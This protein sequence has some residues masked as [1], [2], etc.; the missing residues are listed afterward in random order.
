MA[1]EFLSLQVITKSKSLDTN[2]LGYYAASL[3][4]RSRRF[5]KF[6][7]FIFKDTEVREF[8]GRAERRNISA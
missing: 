2:A 8:K 3:R 6:D 5:E 1:K 7:V 4:N